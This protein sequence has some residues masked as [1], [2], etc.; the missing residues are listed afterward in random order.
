MGNLVGHLF[1]DR[2][3]ANELVLLRLEVLGKS[4]SFA[5][6]VSLFFCQALVQTVTSDS[7]LVLSHLSK[8]TSELLRVLRFLLCNLISNLLSIDI[9]EELGELPDGLVEK[10]QQLV[11]LQAELVLKLVNRLELQSNADEKSNLDVRE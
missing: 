6:F 8:E 11:C 10:R 2:V 4:S 7:L 1:A 9:L 5:V 3:F